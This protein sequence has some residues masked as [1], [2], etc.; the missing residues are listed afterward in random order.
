MTFQA[1]AIAPECEECGGIWLPSD[2]NA[3]GADFVDDGPLDRLGFWCAE[4]WLR[5]FG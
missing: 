2:S 5:E 4:C 3:G 1:V